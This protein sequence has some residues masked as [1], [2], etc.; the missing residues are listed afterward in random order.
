MSDAS[1][2]A[3]PQIVDFG[4]AKI[5]GPSNTASE[6][7]GTLGYVAPEVLK[8]QP[9][10]FSCDVWSLGCIIY[11][12]LSGSLPFDHESQKETI[13]MTLSDEL[14]FDLPCWDDV[15][16]DAKDLV[17]KLMQKDPRNR[18]S[19]ANML[20]HPWFNQARGKYAAATPPS[21]SLPL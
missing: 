5:I 11:A 19:L 1:D 14:V 17:K 3:V 16:P 13:R 12:L 6:P 15:S 9:Y 18:I 21:K 7:F 8:K 20:A 2:G 10:T 4:L